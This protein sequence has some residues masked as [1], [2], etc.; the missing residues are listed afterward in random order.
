MENNVAVESNRR[1]YT[2]FMGRLHQ[3][4]L[5]AYARKQY[6]DNDPKSST[7]FIDAIE[8]SWQEKIIL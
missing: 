3:K 5:G 4:S 1:G 2:G 7:R 8:K 6:L